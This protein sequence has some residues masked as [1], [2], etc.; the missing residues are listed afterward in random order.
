[1]RLGFYYFSSVCDLC[2]AESKR[3]SLNTQLVEDFKGKAFFYF[4]FLSFPPLLFEDKISRS[5][6]E[7]LMVTIFCF[8]FLFC[9]VSD[10]QL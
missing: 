10:D 5:E 6:P 2:L 3:K 8:V 7:R 9:R 4:F 1:M